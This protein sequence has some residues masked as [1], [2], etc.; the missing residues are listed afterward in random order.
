MREFDV[1]MFDQIIPLG[2][3]DTIRQAMK[4]AKSENFTLI[5]AN[6]HDTEEDWI[7]KYLCYEGVL[8]SLEETQQR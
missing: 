2:E 4:L 1:V 5:S 3:V 7:P 6:P 8:Y